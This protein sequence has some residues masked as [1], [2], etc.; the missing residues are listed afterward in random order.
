MNSALSKFAYESTACYEMQAT[1]LWRCLKELD[2]LGGDNT[3]EVLAELENKIRLSETLAKVNHKVEKVG[4]GCF[5]RS[6]SV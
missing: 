1:Q 2:V 4:F 6:K 5:N 3:S